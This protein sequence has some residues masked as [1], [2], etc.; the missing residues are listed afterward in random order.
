MKTL[1]VG[2][3]Y[4]GK[5]FLRLLESKNNKF[6]LEYIVDKQFEV[7]EYKC[8]KDIKQIGN[9][10]DDIKCAIVCTPTM[11][12]FEIV[13]Y[14]LSNNINVLVEKPLA[15]TS[16]EVDE[17]YALA[18]SNNL[19]LLVDHTFLYNQSIQYIIDLI[20]SKEIG[21]LMHIS[22]ERTNLGP[23]RNDVSC[24]WDLA[25]HD[26][27]ILNAI[28]TEFPNKIS[29]AGFSRN[30]KNSF[31]MLNTSL[32]WE[33][34]FVSIFVSWLHPEKSRKI[35]FVG[36]EKM[37]VFDDLNLNEPIKIFN[38][39]VESVTE[40]NDKFDSIFNFSIGDVF[41]PYIKTKEPL[42]EVLN[43]FE[44]RLINNENLNYLNT[45]KLTKNTVK[46]LEDIEKSII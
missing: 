5:N 35:K 7:D 32:L 12:H 25:T 19:T 23:I 10:I 13:K 1:L 18:S 15:T 40:D 39:K 46:L 14:L 31:D 26:I 45:D 38:K 37:I 42:S 29:S 41:S 22:F 34:L 43:D 28:I 8:F 4:W 36:T 16:Q 20:K 3:G 2:A 27:S 11:T 21:E 30:S 6:E 33:S 24:L 44:N 17:L 9:L